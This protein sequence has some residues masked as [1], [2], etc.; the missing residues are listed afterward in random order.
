LSAATTARVQ[1]VAFEFVDPLPRIA[2]S[3]SNHVNHEK[4]LVK[5]GDLLIFKI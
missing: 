5:L 3:F 2:P 4:E 1:L